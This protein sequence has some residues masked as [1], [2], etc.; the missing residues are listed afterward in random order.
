MTPFNIINIIL[1]AYE[2]CQYNV[3]CLGPVSIVIATTYEKMGIVKEGCH[4][5][6]ILSFTFHTEIR[7]F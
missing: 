3:K 1:L 2:N 4:G 6:D 7:I 5:Y